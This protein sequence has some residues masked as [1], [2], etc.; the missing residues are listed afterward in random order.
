MSS[1]TLDNSNTSTTEVSQAEETTRKPY[2]FANVVD[3]YQG[4]LRL[5]FSFHDG[6]EGGCAMVA[7]N[8][9]TN[10]ERAGL[11]P[12]GRGRISNEIISAA[13][14]T[15]PKAIMGAKTEEHQSLSD[16]VGLQVQLPDLQEAAVSNDEIPF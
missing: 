1:L 10:P 13:L 16:F 3:F 9:H 8:P 6:K 12:G 15:I 7:W 4:L 14:V 5:V 2:S 11:F